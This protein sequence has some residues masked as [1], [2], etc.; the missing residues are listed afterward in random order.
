MHRGFIMGYWSISILTMIDR[1]GTVEADIIRPKPP[2]AR[3]VDFSAASAAEK[4]GGSFSLAAYRRQ[5]PQSSLALG[6]LPQGGS[7]S[8]TSRAPSPTDTI[9]PWCGV[10]GAN[11]VRPRRDDVGI[12]P[13]KFYPTS[14]CDCR[15]GCLHPPAKKPPQAWP[16]EAFVV[17]HH[18]STQENGLAVFT[19]R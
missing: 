15:G 4:D 19:N 18:R 13:Y 8:G 10:V 12:V 1:C 11:C 6:Q 2:S 5:L 16:A 7:Q 3:E 17:S 14:V 9:P